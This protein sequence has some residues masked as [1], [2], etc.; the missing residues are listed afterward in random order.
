MQVFK[1]IYMVYSPLGLTEQSL[2]TAC[3]FFQG[4]IK[5]HDGAPRFFKCHP[6]RGYNSP[7]A[8]ML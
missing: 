2:V 4:S 6:K 3:S 1:H 5:I 8:A 7:I